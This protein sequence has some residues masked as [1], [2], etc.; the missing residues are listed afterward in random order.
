M[1]YTISPVI[2]EYWNV[3]TGFYIIAA[4]CSVF[5]VMVI[6]FYK[7]QEITTPWFF[8]WIGLLLAGI[9]GAHSISY[10]PEKHYANTQVIGKFVSYQP[11][12][13]NEQSG[14][15][16]ADHHYMYVVYDIEDHYVIF[17]SSP[18]VSWPKQAVFYR[19]PTQ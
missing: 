12:G 2:D 14:K 3:H 1:M 9:F 6:M 13:Y 16:R 11:E 5:I 17:Q 18:N 4:F 10:Q 15:S 19:N 8:T 7:E